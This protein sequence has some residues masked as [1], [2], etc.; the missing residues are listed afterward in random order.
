[1]AS[2][3]RVLKAEANRELHWLEKDTMQGFEKMN[4]ALKLRAEG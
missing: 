3:P 4:P 2:N 1:M